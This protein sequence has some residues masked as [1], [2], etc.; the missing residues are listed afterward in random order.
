MEG[1]IV[2]ILSNLYFVN[3]NG[4]IYECHSRG[5]FRNDKVTPTVGDYVKFDDKDNYILEIL[6]RRNTLVRPLVSNIDQAF[7]VTSCK[8]PDFSSNLLDKLL[9]ILEFHNIKPVICLTKKDL[10]TKTELKEIKKIKKYYRKIGYVVLWNT[11]LFRIK[12]LF[13][14]KTTVFT[15][16]T[17]AG[18]SSL[19]NKLNKNLKLETGEISKA[20]GRGK[21]TT[22]H[23][24]LIEL[25]KGKV[26]DTPGFSSISFD[27][28][29]KSD[30]KNSFIEFSKFSCPYQDC[31]HLKEKE[32][33][34][35]EAFEKGK[36]LSSRYENYQK[37]ILN[38]RR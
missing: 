25:F 22:R 33:K 28:L 9:V 36:I 4:R 35:K 23:V 29:D 18:K 34:V 13:K 37:I 14:N 27:E 3:S 21:H 32:C 2:K 6:P 17:G 24:E 20:L 30:I 8:S 38:D 16:Q 10:L 26:L 12:R 5:R 19:L 7:I 31:M 1:Q 11:N 15:G